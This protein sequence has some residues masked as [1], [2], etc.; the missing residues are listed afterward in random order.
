[1]RAIAVAALAEVCAELAEGGKEI[2]K[3]IEVKSREIYEREAGSIG[4]I[5]TVRAI[6]EREDLNVARG[7]AAALDLARDLCRFEREI[8]EELVHKS[9]FS[10]ARCACKGGGLAVLYLLFYVAR[11]SL[12]SLARFRRG[13][14]DVEACEA[15]DALVFLCAVADIRLRD[16]HHGLDA[17]VL[18][19]GYELIDG[20]YDGARLCR[21]ENYKQVVEISHRGTYQGAGALAH[22]GYDDAVGGGIVYCH[23]DVVADE[24]L[25][26]V[27]LE[28]TLRTTGYDLARI[29]YSHVEEAAEAL[30][31][32]SVLFCYQSCS[33]F[34]QNVNFSCHFS[35]SEPFC[36]ADRRR[37]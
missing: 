29:K 32:L 18:C 34:L 1:M 17:A 37:R 2:V 16:D 6:A 36:E 7:M 30:H 21:G 8:R 25:V 23:R 11:E 12:C 9:G 33:S 27:A 28:I 20:L 3:R 24:H 15:V 4:K 5:A 13:N 22:G 19:D 14:E 35:R 26:L 10:N 31:Y